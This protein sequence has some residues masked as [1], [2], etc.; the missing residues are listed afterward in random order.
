VQP[1]TV[2]KAKAGTFDSFADVKPKI[3]VEAE[4]T[5]LPDGTFLARQLKNQP[6]ESLKNPDKEPD[7]VIEA[8]G[9]VE[10]IDPATRR[11]TLMGITFQLTEQTK[12]V[13]VVK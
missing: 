3:I 7:K 11:V 8:V 6:L 2:F 9:K 10:K 13:S 1:D 12:G 5:Y 4:G